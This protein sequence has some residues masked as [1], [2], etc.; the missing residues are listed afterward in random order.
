MFATGA[1]HQLF[2]ASNSIIFNSE[3]RVYDSY[4]VYDQESYG[5]R[6]LRDNGELKNYLRYYNIGGKILDKGEEHNM[7]EYQDKFVGKNKI[8]NNGGSE[9]WK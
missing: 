6:W 9:V 5:A 3:G 7:T 4:Y 1:I 2:G 8:Y